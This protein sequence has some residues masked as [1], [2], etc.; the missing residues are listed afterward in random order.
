MRREKTQISKIRNAKQEI[1]TNT[2]EIQGII[3][4]SIV[5]KYHIYL[6]HSSIVGHPG[7]FHNLATVNSAAI[8][9]SMQVPLE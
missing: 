7:Y 1:T 8:K 5:Y 9:M 6:I 3:R 4:D 2:M